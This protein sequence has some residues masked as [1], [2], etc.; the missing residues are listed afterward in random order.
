[1]TPR[2]QTKTD[3]SIRVS[4]RPLKEKLTPERSLSSPDTSLIDLS[5]LGSGPFGRPLPSWGYR[6]HWNHLG[7]GPMAVTAIMDRWTEKR[8]S[9]GGKSRRQQGPSLWSK[10]SKQAKRLH[11]F[12][13]LGSGQKETNFEPDEERERM[14]GQWK[15][16]G[17]GS[18]GRCGGGGGGEQ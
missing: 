16:G 17:R 4:K 12:A 13:A 15:V 2:F 10:D 8:P 1:M 6:S 3:Y 9:P 7:H 5:Q 14:E 11:V 18:V